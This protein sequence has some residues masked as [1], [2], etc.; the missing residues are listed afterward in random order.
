MEWWGKD[1]RLC[2]NFKGK[3]EEVR[4][5]LLLNKKCKRDTNHA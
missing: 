5:S 1:D 4:I 2:V 3:S